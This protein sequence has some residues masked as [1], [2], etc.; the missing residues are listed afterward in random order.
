MEGYGFEYIL[1]A[2]RDEYAVAKEHKVDLAYDRS[3]GVEIV[4]DIKQQL[5]VLNIEGGIMNCPQPLLPN[6]DVK[7]SFERNPA[8]YALFHDVLDGPKPTALDNGK[9]IDIK[10]CYMELEYVSSP[11]LR[12]LHSQIVEKP[13][14]YLSP[15]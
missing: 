4:G 10:D 8:S 7:L 2:N 13:I 11:Y 12:N 9:A 6:T 15:H 3:W 1:L 14:K 5:L